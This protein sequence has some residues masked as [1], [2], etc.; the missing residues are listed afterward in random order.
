[1]APKPFALAPAQ[2]VTGPLDYSKTD[3]AK[4]YKAAIQQVSEQLFDCEPEGLFQFLK[5]VQDRAEEMGW[6]KS[7]LQIG[8]PDDEDSPK[9]DFLSNYGNLTLEQVVASEMVHINSEERA[10]QDTYMLYKCL[11]ASLSAEAKKKVLIWSDQYM[12]GHSPKGSGVALLKVIIRESH[13]DTNATT[14]QIRTKL[15]NLDIYMST[16][17][18]DIGKFNTYVKLLV[19]S[20]TARNQTTSDLLINLFKGYGAVSDEVF[21]A[22]LTRKQDD[23]EEGTPITPDE[24]MLA[25]KNKFDSMREKGTWNAPTAEEKIIALEA[26][27]NK[28]FKTLKKTSNEGKKNAH[29]RNESNFKNKK[30][31][32]Q[33]KHPKLWDR[34]K[35]G[36]CM[37]RKY[38]ER[39]WYWCG[40]LTGGKCEKWRA[41]SPK[42]CKGD[43]S[44]E[45]MQRSFMQTTPA[46]PVKKRQV[47]KNLE[48]KLKVAKAYTAQLEKTANEYDSEAMSE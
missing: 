39:T 8:D 14:N 33:P 36:D 29:K 17:N 9:E 22:W 23:H 6:N 7:I 19:Q 44:L 26:R 24:L 5:E 18:S 12:I 16:I 42:D 45:E 38:K 20:L 41:H 43:R 13:I 11:M 2:S 4:I 10:A 37:E 40:K 31:K 25:A 46:E 21:R 32:P 34:P 35:A 30:V 15:S 28:T 27:F 47:S 48:K 3:H 1:M